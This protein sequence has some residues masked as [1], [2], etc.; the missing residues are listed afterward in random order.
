MRSLHVAV[1]GCA[2]ACGLLLGACG[3]EL[4]GL[5]GPDGGMEGGADSGPPVDVMTPDLGTGETESGTPCLCTDPL[6]DNTWTFVAYD[7]AGRPPCPAQ[8]G[9]QQ[10]TVENPTAGATQ[11]A[12]TCNGVGTQ[13]TCTG[14]VSLTYAFGSSA[15]CNSLSGTLTCGS[16]CQA[17]N[18]G[19][20]GGGGNYQYLGF[21]GTVL[22][23]GGTCNAPTVVTNV[24]AASSQQGRSCALAGATGS[25]GGALVCVPE[26]G[27]PYGTCIAKPGKQVCPMG[28]PN[29]HFVGSGVTDTRGCGPG[30]CTCSLDR[31]TCSTPSVR[32]YWGTNN[33]SGSEWA[34]DP[35]AA[36]GSCVATG[37][38][39]VGTIQSCVFTSTN[40]NP[41]CAF[42]GVYA[43]S[44]ALSL[45]NAQ[46]ICCR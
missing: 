24:P 15:Q 1:V 8:Y 27:A 42:K 25:C 6:P 32:A 45:D 35:R 22:P 4:G 5:E 31:G 40:A 12:C 10:D 11:C 41:T 18:A 33:C 30:P 26:P 34:N 37:W 38:N 3:L 7:G 2:L 21:S 17:T 9:A 20:G 14:N 39:G 43:P 28:Y 19:G 16:S 29:T 44:G 23:Q 13:P 36:N 46:T